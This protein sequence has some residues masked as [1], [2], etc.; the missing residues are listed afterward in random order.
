[1]N[2]CK[3]QKHSMAQLSCIP[4]R[5]WKSLH[6]LVRYCSYSTAVPRDSSPRLYKPSH[7]GFIVRWRGLTFADPCLGERDFQCLSSF[8]K[9]ASL[10][11]GPRLLAKVILEG[12][13]KCVPLMFSRRTAGVDVAVL[14]CVLAAALCPGLFTRGCIRKW[15]QFIRVTGPRCT[16]THF[17]VEYSSQIQCVNSASKRL[18]KSVEES[19]QSVL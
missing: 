2:D 1:M 8:V 19:Q 6:W 13:N 15:F 14:L 3:K 7:M 10:G 4:N 5:V 11:P 17:T 9:E 18:I 16:R 12:K